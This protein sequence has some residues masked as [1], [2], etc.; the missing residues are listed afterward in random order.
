MS[1]QFGPKGGYRYREGPTT[2]SP[3]EDLKPE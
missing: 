1:E 3:W 2:P